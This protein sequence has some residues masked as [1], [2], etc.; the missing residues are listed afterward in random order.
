MS[1]LDRFG[2]TDEDVIEAGIELTPEE[3]Q[4]F[5]RKQELATLQEEQLLADLTPVKEISTSYQ[6]AHDLA[7]QSLDFL[8]AMCM[9]T[10][11]QF[12]FPPVFL[13]AWTW[14]TSF[15]HKTRDFSQLCLG[16]PRGFGKS[17]LMKVF[18]LYCIL[19][20]KKKFILIVGNTATLAENILSDIMDM[21]D[22]PNIKAV[23][24]DWRIGIEKDTQPVKKFGFRGRNIILVALGAGGSLRGLNLKNERPDV[25]V[26]DDIQSAEDA[27]SPGVSDK[28][29]RWMVGTAMKAKSPLGCLY[30]FIGNMY[31]TKHSILRKLKSNPKWIKFI[32]GGILSDGTS[33]WEELQPIKQLLSEYESDL[34][35]G[36]P[37]IFFAEVLN[38]EN[39]NANKLIDLS[40]LPSIPFDLD[41]PIAGNF[42]IIDPSND[43]INSDA[44][45]IGYFEV[46]DAKPVLVE[47]IEGRF[48]PGDTIT[49]ALKLALRRNCRVI[50]I[51]SNAYQYSLLYWFD[52]ICA[53]L[54]I[55]GIHAVEIYSGSYSKN[56][57]ILSMLKGYLAGEIFVAPDCQGPVH[58]QITEFNAMK[59]DN[60]DGLLDLLTYAP[61]VIEMYGDLV[62]VTD[63]VLNQEYASAKVWEEHE[64]SC[65]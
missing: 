60:T 16:L 59:R 55:V 24:G 12:C 35:M 21:L 63:I 25:M 1:N 33:L 31:P 65:F 47:L 2:F 58:L 18:I 15:A 22:E 29:E 7:K 39:A 49:N 37:E 11:W 23:F 17:T 57:R 46:H 50:A 54:G 61:K 4:E 19:F 52:F 13:A 14:L 64:N 51:E 41:E 38:D 42:I 30:L 34:A 56:S 44:V 43:K 3:E 32:A 9:P 10:I 8:A 20:T 62:A 40:K 27:E 28:L 26:F 36:H 53:Q 45:S 5:I 48:S 6:E